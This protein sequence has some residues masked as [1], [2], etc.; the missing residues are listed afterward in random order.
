MQVRSSTLCHTAVKRL[1]I[2][3]CQPIA[4]VCAYEAKLMQCDILNPLVHE[5]PPMKRSVS[6]SF[7]IH[8]FSLMDSSHDYYK[9]HRKKPGN[10]KG[11]SVFLS[12]VQPLMIRCH[13]PVLVLA[14]MIFAIGISASFAADAPHLEL[15]MIGSGKGPYS[16]P[17]GQ[18][19]QLMFEIL[20]NGP[21]EVF[22]TRGDA[23]LDPNSNGKWQLV[24][25]ESMGNFHLD[26]LQ[27]A[28]WTFDLT[29]P[30][31]IQAPNA[32]NGVPQVV[33]RIHI[34]YSGVDGVQQTEQ[35]QFPLS[36][37][38]AIVQRADYSALIVVGG[39]LAVSALCVLLYR[40]VSK[41]SLTR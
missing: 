8:P 2:D 24:H 31:G 13:S 25:S 23:Y 3:E 4:S 29:M 19:T 7:C 28:I 5:Q 12:S 17:A 6:F 40:H 20:N 36:V 38:G 30:P 14:V 18:T 10:V 26:Y 22:L 9:T 11:A 35:K 32:T 16:A 39:V 37:P 21:G 27:S 34:I 41:R 33:L 1:L 15:S